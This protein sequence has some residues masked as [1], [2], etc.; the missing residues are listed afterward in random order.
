MALLVFV[1]AG[2]E[3]GVLIPGHS[4]DGERR[5]QFST[6]VVSESETYRRVCGLE[7]HRKHASWK[8][9]V[10]DLRDQ[11]K[12]GGPGGRCWR[13]SRALPLI[14]YCWC[15]KGLQLHPRPGKCSTPPAEQLPIS[16]DIWGL[17]NLVRRSQEVSLCFG[18][19]PNSMELGSFGNHWFWKSSIQSR[20][21]GLPQWVAVAE[22]TL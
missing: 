3:G 19:Q 12:L 21:C 15:T 11:K 13:I 1:I 8:A 18:G 4:G 5:A 2:E 7:P 10:R 6:T 22:K 9:G 20:R 14:A 16:Q 17:V